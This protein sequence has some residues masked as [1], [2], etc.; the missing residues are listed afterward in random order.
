MVWEEYKDEKDS[1]CLGEFTVL[2]EEHT[3]K[4]PIII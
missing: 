2:Q 1:S 4:Q 3:W